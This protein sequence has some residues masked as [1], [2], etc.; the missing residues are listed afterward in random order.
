MRSGW[1]EKLNSK[2]CDWE[3]KTMSIETLTVH[4]SHGRFF[5][6]FAEAEEYER[7]EGFRN[8]FETKYIDSIERVEAIGT[9]SFILTMAQYGKRDDL[10]GLIGLIVSL[11][12][13]AEEGS[14][15]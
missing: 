7:L 6:I 15:P 11:L 2:P 12:S 5:E 4:R 9:M 3:T 13:A 8:S 14:D 1:P 10:V